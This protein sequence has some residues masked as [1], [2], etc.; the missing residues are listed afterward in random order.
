M[1]IRKNIVKSPQAEDKRQ[2]VLPRRA[3]TL[4]E[5]SQAVKVSRRFLEG[6]INAGRLRAM[7]FGTRCTRVRS[8]DLEQWMQ[9][10]AV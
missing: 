3:F 5:V 7:K 9:A 2:E 6:E 8:E 4:G 10:G 1:T